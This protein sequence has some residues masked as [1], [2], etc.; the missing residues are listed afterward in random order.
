[1]MKQNTLEDCLENLFKEFFC[2]FR[3][4]VLN[5][6]AEVE[7]VECLFHE[8]ANQKVE[9]FVTSVDWDVVMSRFKEE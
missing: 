2:D 4:K 8:Y 6:E 3:E 1:M 7:D 5:E 9:D